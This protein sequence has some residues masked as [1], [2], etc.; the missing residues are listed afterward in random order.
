V[1]RSLEDAL[2]VPVR[3]DDDSGQEAPP[4]LEAL[5]VWRSVDESV[6]DQAQIIEAIKAGLLAAAGTHSRANAGAEGAQQAAA[7]E[8]R[9]LLALLQ[10]SIERMKE[11]HLR[12]ERVPPR[13][14]TVRQQMRTL[15]LEFER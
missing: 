11:L 6:R 13:L 7:E 2:G 15:L 3:E 10:A 14:Q 4:P 1:V 12:S 9:S 5:E 8:E